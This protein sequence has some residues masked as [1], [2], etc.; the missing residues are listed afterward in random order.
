M[1]NEINVQRE[2]L[3]GERSAKSTPLPLAVKEWLA[4]SLPEMPGGVCVDFWG[5]E[6]I[7]SPGSAGKKTALNVY[8]NNPAAIKALILKKDSLALAEAY[9]RGDLQF[10][11]SIDDLL[12]VAKAISM[13]KI[14]TRD[15]VRLFLSALPFP[16][17]GVQSTPKTCLPWLSR[18]YDCKIR[19][20]ESI[21]YHYD[22][23]NE[24]YQLFLDPELVY[25]AAYF[26]SASH[27]LKNAQLCK[28]DILCRK[29]DLREG[30]ALLDI[31][32]GWGGF[33]RYAA[34]NYRVKGCGITLSQKQ[35]DYNQARRNGSSAENIEVKLCDYS[36]LTKRPAFDKA[37]SIGMIEHVKLR[38]YSSYFRHVYAALKPGA[39]FLNQG[40]CCYDGWNKNNLPEKFIDTYIFPDGN[41]ARLP[42]VIAAAEDAGFETI[43]VDSWRL[44]YA[45]TLRCWAANLERS[46]ARACQ[47][48]GTRTTR[49]WLLYLVGSA[50]SFEN[51]YINDYCIL[52]KKTR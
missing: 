33:L 50:Q 41:L 44:H 51:N 39:L 24:F 15:A 18:P 11:G 46:Y 17:D 3:A 32:A 2:F 45:R 22:K 4:R 1:R 29:L 13:H 42:D 14:E 30:E 10:E 52:F 5:R 28:L 34:A 49:L 47:L 40:I 7:F 9:L 21:Q 35:V 8:I 27:D 37:C 25:S 26:L 48:V 12:H 23:S 6:K 19:A 16:S 36:D 38:N 31:G 43:Q 20:M